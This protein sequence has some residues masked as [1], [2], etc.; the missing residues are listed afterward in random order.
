MS[1]PPRLDDIPTE[2]DARQV[3]H[4]L[5]TLRWELAPMIEFYQR[6]LG[7][8]SVVRWMGP[9]TTILLAAILAVLITRSGMP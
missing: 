1:G 6:A 9:I 3:M 7:V 8:L 5:V 2:V 4:E